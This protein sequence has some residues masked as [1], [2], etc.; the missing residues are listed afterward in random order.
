MEKKTAR[1]IVTYNCNRSCPGCCNQHG[2]SVRKVTN[3]EELLKYE[4]IIVTGGE[5]MLVLSDVLALVSTLKVLGYAG[6]FYLYT[7]FWKP[8][9]KNIAI[10]DEFDGITFTIH[11][12]ASDADIIALKHLSKE[13]ILKSANFSSRLIIDSRVYD[14]YDLSNI[15]LKNWDVVR[16]LQWKDK[17]EPAP[18]EELIEYLL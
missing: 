5:P 17:C 10:L 11:A 4:E 13:S 14:K 16:K 1:V 2:N 12:E 8:N 9:F 7:A 15:D 18:N 6:R 3:I